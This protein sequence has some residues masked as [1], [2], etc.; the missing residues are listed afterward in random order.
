MAINDLPLNCTLKADFGQVS[1]ADAM[2]RF[3]LMPLADEALL[4]VKPFALPRS[5]SDRAPHRMKA[6][7]MTGRICGRE[8]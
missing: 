5:I 7:A 2:L 1:S 3:W 6:K 8:S 4:S